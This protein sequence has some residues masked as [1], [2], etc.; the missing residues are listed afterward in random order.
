MTPGV[1]PG[2]EPVP[3]PTSIPGD[4]DVDGSC[5]IVDDSWDTPDVMYRSPATAAVIIA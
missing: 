4:Q 1:E 2:D 3:V 5:R